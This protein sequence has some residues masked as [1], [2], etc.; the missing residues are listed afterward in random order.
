MNSIE[1][2]IERVGRNICL[3]Q[4]HTV[5]LRDFSDEDLE[6]FPVSYL[7]K[8]VSS[9]ELQQI[10]YKL[11]EKHKRN[12]VLRLNLPCLKHFNNNK[13]E[14]ATQ[15]DG[16]APPIKFCTACKIN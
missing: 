11:P 12:P 15:F 4:E 5:P 2:I 8:Y 7:E 3:Y 13:T 16:P 1:N 6:Y 14:G 9:I 10:W